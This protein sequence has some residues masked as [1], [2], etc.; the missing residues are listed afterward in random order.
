VHDVEDRLAALAKLSPN[1]LVLARMDVAMLM[2][3]RHEKD[4]ML[5]RD[6]KYLHDMDARAREFADL[7]TAS[8]LPAPTKA[9]MARDMAAYQADFR[10]FAAGWLALPDDIEQT[11]ASGTEVS[12][13][14]DELAAT[15]GK[16]Y[17]EK[18]AQMTQ[19]LRQLLWIEGASIVVIGVL[20]AVLALVIGSAISRRIVGLSAT[21]RRLAEGDVSV[22]IRGRAARDEIGLMAGAV[23]VFRQNKLEADRLAAAQ[24]A[25]RAAKEQRAARLEALVRGFE[26]R[27]SDLVRLLAAGS[28]E[29]EATAQSMAGGAGKASRQV[30]AVSSGAEEASVSVQMVATAADELTASIGEISRQVAQSTRITDRAVVDARRT[31]DIVRTLAERARKIGDVVGLITTIAHQTNLLALNATIEA[32]RAG[33]AGKGFA[34]VAAE[35]KSLSQQ[36]GRATEEIGSQIGLIQTATK[37]AVEAIGGI[38]GIIGDVSATATA[39]AAAVEQQ[40][41]ATGEIARNAQQTASGTQTVTANIAGVSQLA[42]E[43]GAAATQVLGAAGDLSRQAEQLSGEVRTFVAGVRAA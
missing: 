22:E 26:A 30:A 11:R 42:S 2:M 31:D 38:T 4:L 40:L 8:N 5:R 7:L 33:E 14:L 37:E 19:S 24:A 18:R 41:A 3:R 43:T 25:E 21:M 39:I 28:T 20:M 35:V 12:A 15:L 6:A 27:V 9:E 36:T 13:K 17:A 29:L 1:P 32:A 34:V 23:E 10:T 16:A